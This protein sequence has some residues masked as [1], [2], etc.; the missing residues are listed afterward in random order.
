MTVIAADR[1]NL[2]MYLV[3][4][5]GQMGGPRLPPPGM[6]PPFGDQ[7]PPPFGMN[8]AMGHFP[9]AMMGMDKPPGPVPPQMTM[10]STFLL[11]YLW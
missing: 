11:L 1:P 9:N 7:Q 8:P 3:G 2:F 5:P 6:G 4:P 10:V